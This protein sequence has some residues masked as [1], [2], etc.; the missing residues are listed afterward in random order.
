MAVAL[1]DGIYAKNLFK[2]FD[3]NDDKVIN[4]REFILSFATFLNETIDKQI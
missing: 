2:L 1:K 4:F 3:T